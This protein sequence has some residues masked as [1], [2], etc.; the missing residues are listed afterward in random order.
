[1]KKLIFAVSGKKYSG[2]DVCCDHI[3][4]NVTEFG[5]NKPDF[6]K[7]GFADELKKFVSEYFDIPLNNL[8]SEKLKD[9]PTQYQW[10]HIPPY[11]LEFQLN[12]D[13]TRVAFYE[14]FLTHRDFMQIVPNDIL[15]AIY[16]K[17]WINKTF[18]VIK[19]SPAKVFFIKDFRFKK[20]A[21]ALHEESEFNVVKIR[22]TRYVPQNERNDRHISETDLDDYNGFDHYIDNQFMT[23]ERTKAAFRDIVM[24][25]IK[26][27]TEMV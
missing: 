20:E 15:G 9:S 23:L 14:E 6:V 24:F 1:M 21:V 19:Q 18:K 4:K 22:L 3:L 25:E 7:G 17:I 16:P 13:P 10:K 8:Y 27:F 11:N 5:F 26:K 2:K 12:T